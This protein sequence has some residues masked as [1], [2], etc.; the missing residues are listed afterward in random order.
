VKTGTPLEHSTRE[1]DATY[2]WMLPYSTL[3]LVLMIMFSALYTYSYMDTI[4][5]E[6]A[7]AD[8][9]PPDEDV[10]ATLKEVVLAQQVEDFIREMKMEGIAEIRITPHAI[11]LNLSSPAIFDSASA[12]IKPELMPLLS[13]LY[14]HLSRMDNIIVVEGHTD[15]VPIFTQKYTSN[16]E[17]SAAR[18]FS[19][20]Y[21]YIKRGLDPKRL[22]AYGYGEHRPINT[23][24]TELGRAMNRRIELTIM[25]ERTVR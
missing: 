22:L 14:E 3:M 20:I 24:D 16:W 2:L 9:E 25:R 1:E 21:F 19:V 7:I 23:N 12:E 15:N 11:E 4:R 6:K 5:Y 10:S 8:L 13:K 17:L 18:A